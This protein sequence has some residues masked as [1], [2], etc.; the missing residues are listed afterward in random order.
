VLRACN[1]KE[2]HH[3]YT[4][5]YLSDTGVQNKEINALV[6][7]ALIAK[8]DNN[9]LG[10]LP[11]SKYKR[12]MP[13]ND[14]SIRLI[15]AKALCPQDIFHDDV[16]RFLQRKSCDL[17]GKSKYAYPEMNLKADSEGLRPQNPAGPALE[18]AVDDLLVPKRC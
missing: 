13:N 9:K 18:E 11:P 8:A 15:L 12:I 3:I 17:G 2:F 10:G 7:F 1:K 4:R 5:K 14:E 16:K 6:N